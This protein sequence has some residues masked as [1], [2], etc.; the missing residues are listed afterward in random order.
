MISKDIFPGLSTTKMTFQNF[1][2]P[3]IFKNKNLGLS[4]KHGNRV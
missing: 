2:G 1:P 4:R 3:R